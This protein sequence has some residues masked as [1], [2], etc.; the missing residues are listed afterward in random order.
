MPE[1][2]LTTRILAQRPINHYAALDNT[3]VRVWVVSQS[4]LQNLAHY[5]GL[6]ESV[7]NHVTGIAVAAASPMSALATI[8]ELD[9]TTRD[10]LR[11]VTIFDQEARLVITE[12]E[13]AG[14]RILSDQPFVLRVYLR[15]SRR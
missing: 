9:P 12:V 1:T 15:S 13:P 8:R 2:R 11:R 3:P 6:S 10:R 5:F 7:A 14:S 4:D